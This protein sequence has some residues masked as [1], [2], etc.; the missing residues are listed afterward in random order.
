MTPALAQG[1]FWNQVLFWNQVGLYKLGVC[2]FNRF[3]RGLLGD[4]GS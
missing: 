3:L 4:T 2:Y 1:V